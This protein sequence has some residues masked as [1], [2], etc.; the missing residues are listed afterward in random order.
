MSNMVTFGKDIDPVHL[1][2]VAKALHDHE[3]E[4]WTW[5]EHDDDDG[6]RGNGYVRITPTDVRLRYRDR[7]A[8]AI[9]ASEAFL[10]RTVKA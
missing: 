9:Y 3:G 5:P 2:D 6:Y 1:D 7:A 10:S 8:T 4:N